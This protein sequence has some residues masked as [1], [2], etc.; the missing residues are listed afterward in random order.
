VC[1]G[2][3][4]S[5]CGRAGTGTVGSRGTVGNGSRGSAD[6]ALA[7]LGASD[8]TAEAM[9]DAD[10]G[11]GGGAAAAALADPGGWTAMPQMRTCWCPAVHDARADTS[12]GHEG[13][14]CASETL[15][16][17][18][19]SIPAQGSPSTQSLHVVGALMSRCR[20][21]CAHESLDTSTSIGSQLDARAQSASG[22]GGSSSQPA[23]MPA[24]T[25]TAA[26]RVNVLRVRRVTFRAAMVG[27]LLPEG[28]EATP[29]SPSP[30]GTAVHRCILEPR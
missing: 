9:A 11:G 25:K 6:G 12:V 27:A 13:Q 20:T 2:S 24:I 7:A 26:F 18:T 19:R 16:L 3:G 23:I 29:G 8:G 21:C 5:Y 4:R 28:K 30:V 17:A 14:I 10:G 15:P 22:L 1:P